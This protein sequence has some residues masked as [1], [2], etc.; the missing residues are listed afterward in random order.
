MEADTSYNCIA[1]YGN[2][3]TDYLINARLL[4]C[5]LNWME[6]L[7]CC[8]DVMSIHGEG[9]TPKLLSFKRQR[10]K[11]IKMSFN[12]ITGFNVISTG[13]SYLNHFHGYLI[14]VVASF[15][16]D[17]RYFVI[18]INDQCM[19]IDHLNNLQLIQSIADS[20]G[21]KYGISYQRSFDKGPEWYALGI[22]TGDENS[23]EESLEVERHGR[24]GLRMDDEE[25]YKGSIRDLY[26]YNYV[27]D[28]QLKLMIGEMR[29]KDFITADANHGSL[30]TFNSTLSLWRVTEEQIARIRPL[31]VESG[32]IY[33]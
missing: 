11:L 20:T 10:S 14:N 12:N 8:P 21:S 19:S 25:I 18:S 17:E 26:P 31:A 5:I 15:D 6:S 3:E 4:Q 22:G 29:L 7:N 2:D 9:Y 28:F 13:D 23:P 27:N 1:F 33:S 32:I 16:S 30:I 24:W